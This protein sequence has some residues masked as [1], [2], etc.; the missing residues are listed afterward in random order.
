[1]TGRMLDAQMGRISWSL[2]SEKSFPEADRLVWRPSTEQLRRWKTKVE[3]CYAS[4]GEEVARH[5]IWL[6][7]SFEATITPKWRDSLEKYRH[8]ETM[9]NPHNKFSLQELIH[10]VSEKSREYYTVRSD[11]K[12]LFQDRMQKGRAWDVFLWDTTSRMESLGV[13]KPGNT[14]P[15]CLKFLLYWM[16]TSL[17]EGEAKNKITRDTGYT[18]V[19]LSME[20]ISKKLQEEEDKK[21]VKDGGKSTSGSNS[22]SNKA[23]RSVNAVAKGGDKNG[24]ASKAP[25]GKP[26]SSGAKKN[27]MGGMDNGLCPEGKKLVD[28]PRCGVDG[29]KDWAHW[30]WCDEKG[31]PP[32]QDETRGEGWTAG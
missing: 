26:T 21:N 3:Y 18:M 23:S 10:R 12:D 14:W 11:L 31:W 5:P 4:L 28:A 7:Q 6:L 17:D 1:M 22:T 2:W 29:C 16:F 19:K 20:M 32:L 25:A 13:Y 30:G 24:S 27:K 9:S 15:T 8:S